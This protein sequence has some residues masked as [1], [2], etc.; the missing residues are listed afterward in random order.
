MTEDKE[1][2]MELGRQI[3]RASEDIESLRQEF[4]HFLEN[5]YHNLC[6]KVDKLTWRVAYIV[7]AGAAASFIFQLLIKFIIQ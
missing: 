4:N 1:F 5:D 2:W 7:G 3:G 6:Q